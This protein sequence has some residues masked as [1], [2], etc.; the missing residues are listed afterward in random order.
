MLHSR[1]AGVPYSAIAN[2]AFDKVCRPLVS[3]SCMADFLHRDARLLRNVLN[4]RLDAWQQLIS[5][6]APYMLAAIGR[7]SRDYDERMTIFLEILDRLRK[8]DFA[9]LRSFSFVPPWPRG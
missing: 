2:A 7:Y 6:F 8:N 5:R 9:R 3:I 4:G 1:P